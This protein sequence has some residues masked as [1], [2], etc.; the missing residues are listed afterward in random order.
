[1]CVCVCV[2]VCVHVGESDVA[3][4]LYYMIV[5][6]INSMIIAIIYVGRTNHMPARFVQPSLVVLKLDCC[7]LLLGET[8]N[9]H[10]FLGAYLSSS[11]IHSVSACTSY[12]SPV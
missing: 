12:L 2:C 7:N 10:K 11:C 9:E 4:Y 5:C 6:A 8:S 1:M 3:Y